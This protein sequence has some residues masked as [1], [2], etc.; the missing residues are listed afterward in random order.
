MPE[1]NVH[2]MLKKQRQLKPNMEDVLSEYLEGDTKRIALDFIAYLQQNKMKP[3]WTAANCWK[4]VY[5][6]KP[7]FYIRLAS[8][9]DEQ[10]QWYFRTKK[11]SDMTDW[12]HSW[13]IY[14][15]LNHINE[16]QD[17]I[18]I[19]GW[20]SLIWD[21]LC[22][23]QNCGVGCAPG[24]TKTI[25]GK[26]VRGLCTCGIHSGHLRVFFVNPDEMAI[27]CIKK[28]LELERQARVSNTAK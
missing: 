5:K 16:Y 9:G 21:N 24:S 11:P 20:Q 14:P 1:L 8:R 17:E 28:L 18:I 4:T 23:C 26:E 25:V 6:G 12:A 10:T 27:S 15:Y 13:V 7:I 19:E 2:E 22:Y 3:M